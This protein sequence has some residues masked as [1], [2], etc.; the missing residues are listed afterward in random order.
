MEIENK[1]YW[2]YHYMVNAAGVDVECLKSYERVYGFA[3]N[4]VKAIDMVAYGEPQIVDFGTGDKAGFT[5]VQLI[6]TSNISA[7]FVN[8]LGQIYLDV[9][10]CKDFDPK[11]VDQVLYD[12]FFPFTV[13]GMMI[14]RDASQQGFKINPT[15]YDFP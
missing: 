6:E 1:N 11:V 3:K 5:L 7:H 9:F 12:W 10:S 13:S 14:I 2:G 15:T 4:L 8:E